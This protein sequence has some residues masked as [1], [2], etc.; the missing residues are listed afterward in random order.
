M[1]SQR[2]EWHEAALSLR[3]LCEL[4]QLPFQVLSSFRLAYAIVLHRSSLANLEESNS[5]FDLVDDEKQANFSRAVMY[6]NSG[7]HDRSEQLFVDVLPY[8]PLTSLNLAILELQRNSIAKSFEYA[9]KFLSE[10][11][12]IYGE[13][14]ADIGHCLLGQIYLMRGNFMFVEKVLEN[15]QTDDLFGLKSLIL[16]L[17]ALPDTIK[18]FNWFDQAAK[19]NGYCSYAA[20]ACL[21]R[22]RQFFEAKSYLERAAPIVSRINALAVLGM[23]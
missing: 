3:Q 18:A 13:N 1:S 7:D 22:S 17:L 14:I 8:V 6:L 16:G 12:D 19:V 23:R 21:I 11:K 4:N 15:V 20:A 5:F 9:K 10:A 2:E